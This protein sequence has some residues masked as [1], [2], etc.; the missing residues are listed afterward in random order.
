M[1]SNGF[2]VFTGK[3]VPD[4][5]KSPVVIKEVKANG[6]VI[7]HDTG[8]V[9]STK[10]VG[11]VYFHHAAFTNLTLKAEVQKLN[12]FGA[13]IVLCGIYDIN[14]AAFGHED[15]LEY[16]SQLAKST[17]FQLPLKLLPNIPSKG[18]R[19]D[20]FQIRLTPN[21]IDTHCKVDSTIH[22]D[23]IFTRRLD[24]DK[25]Y[26]DV[27]CVIESAVRRNDYVRVLPS[28]GLGLSPLTTAKGSVFVVRQ[29]L[30]FTA[31]VSEEY[32]AFKDRSSV[33]VQILIPEQWPNS[34]ES[35][36]NFGKTAFVSRGFEDNVFLSTKASKI[37]NFILNEKDPRFFYATK[38]S[39]TDFTVF[40]STSK[41]HHYL[42]VRMPDRKL[43]LQKISSMEDFRKGYDSAKFKVLEIDKHINLFTNSRD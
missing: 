42:A 33:H 27:N 1:I 40:L 17:H 39:G 11:D 29:Y 41:L 16:I 15:V 13:A 22:F 26:R 18:M 3:F 4:T 28:G 21:G 31:H 32:K 8:L 14:T 34:T 12:I 38:L 23:V 37:N 30:G 43:Y 10:L 5:G 24:N 2:Q 9:L 36:A 6:K 19:K 25:M 35:S 20:L 7:H